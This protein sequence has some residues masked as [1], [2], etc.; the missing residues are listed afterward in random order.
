[1]RRA[2][3]VRCSLDLTM[4]KTAASEIQARVSTH[5]RFPYVN[6]K[7]AKDRSLEL[8]RSKLRDMR[9]ETNGARTTIALRVGNN[10]F[11]CGFTSLSR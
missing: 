9:V 8:S 11:P 6:P 3:R 1:M 5:H 10:A 7:V 4:A 2:F